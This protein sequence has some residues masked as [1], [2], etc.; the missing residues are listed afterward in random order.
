MTDT[1]IKKLEMSDTMR[2]LRICRADLCNQN[3]PLYEDED[4][5]RHLAGN[6]LSA[7]EY[8]AAFQRPKPVEKCRDLIHDQTTFACPN[9]YTILERVEPGREFAS[10]PVDAFC[11]NCGQ[12][13]DWHAEEGD[14]EA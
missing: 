13:L 7:I 9:C 6:A 3:C 11:P 5:E 14:G 8:F 1:P 2:A 10:F 12:A 4:C